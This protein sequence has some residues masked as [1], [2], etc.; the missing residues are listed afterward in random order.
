MI[1]YKKNHEEYINYADEQDDSGE[2][3]KPLTK[4]DFLRLLDHAINPPKQPDSKADLLHVI[5]G[6]SPN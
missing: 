4:R 3:E 2:R 6:Y 5:K 1:K